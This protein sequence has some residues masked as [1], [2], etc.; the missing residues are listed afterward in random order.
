MAA[1][2]AYVPEDRGTEA[3]FPDM[4]VRANLS[5]PVIVLLLAARVMRRGA[6]R[7]D[8]DAV[9]ESTTSAPRRTPQVFSTLSGGNQQK[10]I[11]GRWLRRKPRILLLDEPTHGVDVGARTEIYKLIAAAAASGTSI[12]WSAPTTTSWRFSATAS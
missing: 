4:T 5:A 7:R 8:A 10:V 2:F 6:E 3:A 11:L 12:C 1:G 9:I